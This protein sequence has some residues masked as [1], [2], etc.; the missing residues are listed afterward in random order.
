M[1][2][3]ESKIFSIFDY[4]YSH[5]TKERQDFL[6]VHKKISEFDSENLTFALLENILAEH[7]EYNHL[8][9]ICHMPI[10]NVIRDRSLLADDE[11]EY[12]RHYSTHLDF[13]IINHVTKKPLLAIETDGYSYHHE[14]TEQHSRDKKKD[15]ILE[16]YGLPLLRLSTIG[17][18]EEEQIIKA[19]N[20]IVCV[21]GIQA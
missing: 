10:R 14:E 15:H 9:I 1:S 19:L 18:R 8:G 17:S 11:K 12:I 16:M 21:K 7:S 20:E 5:Y 13:L 6:A 3:T 2:V 4:L